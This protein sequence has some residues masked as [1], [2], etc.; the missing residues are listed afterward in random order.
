MVRNEDGSVRHVQGFVTDISRHVHD[1]VRQNSKPSRAAV[2]PGQDEP[3]HK[4]AEIELEKI[5]DRT[6]VQQLMSD[7][8]QLT[9]IGGALLDLKGNVLASTG[10]EDICIKF[11]RAH[12]ETNRYCMESDMVLSQDVRPGEYKIYRCKNNMLDIVMPIM[13]EGRH[14]GNLFTGQ[15][16]FEDEPPDHQLFMEQA[17]RYGFDEQQ[18]LAALKKSTFA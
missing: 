18:Y 2:Q 14:V 11:H 9:G 1:D 13:V 16:F 17:G 3:R 12:P 10:W 6:A 15:F 7:F 4:D 8:C 5:F